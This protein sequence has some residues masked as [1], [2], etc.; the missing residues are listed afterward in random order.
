MFQGLP[1]IRLICVGDEPKLAMMR[2][3]TSAS[4]GRANLH[5]GALGA[6]VDL[7]SGRVTAAWSASTPVEA[8]PDGVRL[9]GA[10]V[11]HWEGVLN[12]A[13]RFSAVTGLGYLGADVVVDAQ[14]GPL[15]LEVNAR[16]GLQIQNV[17][18]RGLWE[19]FA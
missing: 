2:L 17:T 1:D 4:G 18:G 13:S 14:R 5:Q 19:L 9:V 16:P 10:T 6:S 15:I 11:P 3:P 12:A 8:H 7:G